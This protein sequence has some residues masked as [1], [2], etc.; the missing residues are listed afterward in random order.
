MLEQI[1]VCWVLLFEYN[2]WR[3]FLHETAVPHVRLV[4]FKQESATFSLQSCLV[5]RRILDRI[6]ED[7][8]LAFFKKEIKRVG[9]NYYLYTTEL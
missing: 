6:L 8:R 7:I 5:I 2:V 1:N 3:D 4:S 9:G